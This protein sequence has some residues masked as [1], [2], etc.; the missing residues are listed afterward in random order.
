M[1]FVKGECL[2]VC[3]RMR[4][5]EGQYAQPPELDTVTEEKEPDTARSAVQQQV[6]ASTFLKLAPHCTI[7]LK[8]SYDNLR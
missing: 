7:L 6:R 4:E 1:M 2:F 8:I 3:L 5:A